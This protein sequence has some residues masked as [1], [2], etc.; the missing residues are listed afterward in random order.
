MRDT[1]ITSMFALEDTHFWFVGKR[2]FISSA[3]SR[4]P[5][6]GRILDIGCGTGGTTAFFRQFGQV[7]GLETDR[8]AIKLAKARGLSVK[9]GSANLLPFAS[10]SFDLITLCDV[11]YHKGVDEKKALIEAYRVLRPGGWLLITDCA[12][13]WLWSKHDE[14]WEAKYRYSKPHLHGLVQNAGFIVD[15]CTYIFCSILPVVILSRLSW[16]SGWTKSIPAWINT[17]F[18]N[19]L[20]AESHAPQWI[21]RLYGSS[22]LI[23][24]HKP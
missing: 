6:G 24:A 19:I 21:P 8:S 16:R 15:R 14:L 3:L 4:V 9:Q 12:L 1:N 11:L 22:L 13:P 10:H 23:L 7:T 18:T 5:V 20:H 2:A 17:I